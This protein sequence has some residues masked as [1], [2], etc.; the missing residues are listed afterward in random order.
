MKNGAGKVECTVNGIGERAGL[1]ALEEV[2]VALRYH[3]EYYQGE[4]RIKMNSIPKV[5]QFVSYVTGLSVQV[6]KAIIGANAFVHSQGMHQKNASAYEAFSPVEYGVHKQ[7]VVINA[8]NATPALLRDV[9]ENILDYHCND[10]GEFRQI[11]SKLKPVSYT[12]L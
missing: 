3:Q 1:A 9:L 2:A 6:N 5:S 10:E 8:E 7:D 4:T 11:D 12:H